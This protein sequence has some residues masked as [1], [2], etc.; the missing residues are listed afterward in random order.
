MFESFITSGLDLNMKFSVIW[1]GKPLFC[2]NIQACYS[3]LTTRGLEKEMKFEMLTMWGG[4]ISD[5]R[6]GLS[7]RVGTY[8][9]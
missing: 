6:A 1:D 5:F 7:A 2:D 9:A 4:T 3:T 8:P